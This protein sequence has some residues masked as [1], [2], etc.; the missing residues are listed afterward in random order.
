MTASTP[1][2]LRHLRSVLLGPGIVA[3]AVPAILLAWT[4]TGPLAPADLWHVLAMAAG[5]ALI[6]TGVA[7][8]A[9]TIALFDRT[10]HGTL[11]PTD[12]T[13]HL[14]VHGP[15]RYVRN[16]MFSGVLAI[17]LGEAAMLRSPALLAWFAVFWAAL[18]I[19]IPR[20]EEPR[21]EHRFG[22]DYARYRAAVPRWLPRLRPWQPST[23]K[24]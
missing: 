17:L 5:A 8:L 14:V 13:R 18:A 16:P 7:L 15:Y 23:P 22:A 12:P 2:L 11:S 4:G 21:L 10:G 19:A 9:W 24:R 20:V 6:M 3:I 1:G